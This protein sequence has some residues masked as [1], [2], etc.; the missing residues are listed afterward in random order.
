MIERL[1]RRFSMKLSVVAVPNLYFG[2]DVS[3]AGLVTGGDLLAA[4][5]LVAGDFVIIPRTM[6]KSDEAVM[7]DGMKLEEVEQQFQLPVLAVDFDGFA[8]LI[9]G[10][11]TQIGRNASAS[12]V[13][14][15]VAG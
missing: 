2:G 6:L 14:A 13:V 7:L 9:T 11:S 1:N 12:P 5:P 3:V 10:R 4:R 15:A 8:D